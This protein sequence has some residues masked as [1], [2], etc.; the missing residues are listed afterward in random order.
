MTAVRLPAKA[1]FLLFALAQNAAELTRDHVSG[2]NG[3]IMQVHSATKSR[4]EGVYLQSIY[5]LPW[6]ISVVDTQSTVVVLHTAFYPD[7]Y[8]LSCCL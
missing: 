8:L 3:L 7:S 4:K 5:L 6:H 1:G 2:I